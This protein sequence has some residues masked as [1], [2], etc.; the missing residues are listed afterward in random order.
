MNNTLLGLTILVTQSKPKGLLLCDKIHAQGGHSIYFP[1]IEIVDLTNSNPIQQQ[2]AALSH[3]DWVIFV[4]YHAVML[5]LAYLPDKIQPAKVAAIGASTADALQQAGIAVSIFPENDWTSEGLL[6]LPAFQQVEGQKIAI[7]KGEGGRELL[8]QT[9][10][11]RGASVTNLCVY[12]RQVPSS[13]QIPYKN[14]DVLV[15]GSAEGLKNLSK[16]NPS[17]LP[18]PV[19]VPSERVKHYASQ[20]HFKK[21]LLAN[22]PSHDAIIQTLQHL[23][24]DSIMSDSAVVMPPSKKSK[25]H[26]WINIGILSTA[27]GVVV[28]LIA[29]SVVGGRLF[30]MNKQMANV[31]IES[32]QH[33]S[34]LEKNIQQINDVIDNQN[35]N[36]EDLQ[37]SAQIAN[38]APTATYLALA[39]INNQIEQIPLV[40]RPAAQN[41]VIASP[42]DENATWWQRLLAAISDAFNRIVIVRQLP[43]SPPFVPVDQ[44]IIF[45]QNMHA[46]IEN[47]KWGLLHQQPEIMQASLQQVAN[48]IKIYADQNNTTTQ[49]VLKKL[50]EIKE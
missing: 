35:K 41:S 24:K 43:L 12:Q 15:V 17:I 50:A 3:Y 47:A 9:L 49:L 28:L 34:T 36:I 1:T 39:E 22:S 6:A 30:M 40:K 20:L 14:L 45:Y 11:K 10:T 38:A 18:I 7:I 33:I 37:K 31:L 16:D 29:L 19:V 44:Q 48:W 32:Q 8:A 4:S 5:S 26:F 42:L 21:I 25:S 2:L 13:M 27:S 23:K 46:E